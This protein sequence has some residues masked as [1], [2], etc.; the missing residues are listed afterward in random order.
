MQADTIVSHNIYPVIWGCSWNVDMINDS[1]FTGN[2]LEA[3][4][5]IFFFC[6]IVHALSRRF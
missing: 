5:I 3:Y 4:W 1:D 6:Y 2:G